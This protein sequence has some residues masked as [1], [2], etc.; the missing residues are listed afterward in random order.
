MTDRF[1]FPC[2]VLAY[3][4][5]NCEIAVRSRVAVCW[6]SLPVLY[7]LYLNLTTIAS[8]NAKLPMSVQFKQCLQMLKH[9]QYT[10][11]TLYLNTGSQSLLANNVKLNCQVCQASGA[12]IN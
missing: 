5:T 10:S 9:T 8:F 6:I 11:S 3:Y 4:H 1:I 12:S 2:L 7:F